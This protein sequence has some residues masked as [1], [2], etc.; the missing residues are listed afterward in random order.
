M[1]DTYDISMVEKLFRQCMLISMS[2]HEFKKQD[3]VVN[4]F[5]SGACDLAEYFG[6]L[7]IAGGSKVVDPHEIFQMTAH[8]MK[9]QMGLSADPVRK[10]MIF[11]RH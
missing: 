2:N 8:L 1:Y 7:K 9:K 4:I 10:Q 5:S 6:R 11:K 3:S